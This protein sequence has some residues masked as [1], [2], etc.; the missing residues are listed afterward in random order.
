VEGRHYDFG[1]Y[2]GAKSLSQIAVPLAAMVPI[3]RFSLDAGT[4]FARTVLRR[5]DDTE[6]SVDG[7][8]D[9]Q[10]RGAYVLGDDAFVL[11]A[12]VNLPT[13]VS[14]LTATEY[15]VLSAASSSFLAFPVNGYGSGLSLTAGAGGAFRAGEWNLGLAGSLRISDDFTAFHD[16]DGP[17]TYETGL[18]GR[19]R[20][21]AD[22]LIGSAR[23][24]LGLT[25]STF[26]TDQ[27]ATG[28]GT[29]GVYRPG[30]R[31]I[32]E[33]SVTTAIG[34]AILT[35]YAWDFFR[36]AG[37]SAGAGAGNRDNLVAVGAI[38]RIPVSRAVAW[39]PAAELRGFSPEEGSAILMEVASSLRIR[40]S[41]R[42]SVVPTARFNFGRLV[43]PAPGFGHQI[44]GLG[45]SAFV[46]ES[47]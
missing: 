43:E 13:G 18:E 24:A 30:Q 8:T 2:F 12:M 6:I 26:S 21:G 33:A 22:R 9:T 4:Y 41:Q 27:Y 14:D 17:F 44:L 7:L 19:I 39:E 45:V 3:G 11:T 31:W 40:V 46:R 34:P 20:A 37:D 15:A 10:V 1:P 25:F 29:V 35:G 32:G 28:G 23:V 16:A 38:L 47:F 36:T 42:L 5:S